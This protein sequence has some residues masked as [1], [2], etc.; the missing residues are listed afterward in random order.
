VSGQHQVTLPVEAMK[1]AG[2]RVGDR[3]MASS[4]APGV[5]VLER[6]VDPLGALRGDL[7]GV[8][9]PGDL[10]ALRSEWDR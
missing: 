10:D 2:I 6:E 7:T 8:Y 1:A 9:K 4:P 5:V 3:L